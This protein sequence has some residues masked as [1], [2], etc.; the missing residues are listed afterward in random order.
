MC[1][2]LTLKPNGL[3]VAPVGEENEVGP[4][5]DSEGRH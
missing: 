2:M 4:G 5:A 3:Q 1:D